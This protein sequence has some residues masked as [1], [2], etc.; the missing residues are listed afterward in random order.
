MALVPYLRSYHCRW[1]YGIPIHSLMAAGQARL[2]CLS[3]RWRMEVEIEDLLESIMKK[4]AEGQLISILR[5]NTPRRE[6]SSSLCIYA[7]SWLQ[8]MGRVCRK[9][10]HVPYP[11]RAGEEQFSLWCHTQ[12][13]L[14]LSLGKT[15]QIL[16]PRVKTR[17][18]PVVWV[19]T[20]AMSTN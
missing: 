8:N 18:I 5:W 9:F 13:V 4:V 1:F 19:C 17:N 2:N 12:S 11:V 14:G 3:V 6:V 20:V 10:S 7:L 15:F 16:P